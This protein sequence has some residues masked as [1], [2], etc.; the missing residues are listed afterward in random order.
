MSELYTG[1][2]IIFKVEKILDS[3]L[4]GT[5]KDSHYIVGRY[6]SNLQ[7]ILKCIH[8]LLYHKSNKD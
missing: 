8:K 1:T 3:Y 2:T 6:C 5:R 4:E 7:G